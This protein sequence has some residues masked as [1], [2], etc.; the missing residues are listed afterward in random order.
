MR[1]TSGKLSQKPVLAFLFAYIQGLLSLSLSNS[2]FPSSCLPLPSLCICSHLPLFRS[3]NAAPSCDASRLFYVPVFFLSPRAN[4]SKGT[5][6]LPY[7]F[8]YLSLFLHEAVRNFLQIPSGIG[9]CFS[10]PLSGSL[11]SSSRTT[12]PRDHRLLHSAPN[13]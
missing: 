6:F 13:P 8:T 9:I 10:K 4:Y 5:C 1:T 7:F 12:P 3:Q 2:F 11:L